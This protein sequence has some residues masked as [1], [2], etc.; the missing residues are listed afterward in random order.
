MADQTL[1]S[2]AADESTSPWPWPS[3]ADP[4]HVVPFGAGFRACGGA[5]VGC[6]VPVIHAIPR[7]GKLAADVRQTRRRAGG[8]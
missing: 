2:R 3:D 6:P 5:D 1:P 8:D 4:G 7:P